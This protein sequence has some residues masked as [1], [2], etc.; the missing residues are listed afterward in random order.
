MITDL[1]TR[2][3]EKQYAFYLKNIVHG[4]PFQPIVLRG[5]KNKPATTAE[6]HEGIRHFRGNEKHI[7]GKGWVIAWE[8]WTSKILGKQQWPSVVSVTTEEDF[9]YLVKKEKEAGRFKEQLGQ[10]LQWN[11]AI[12]NWLA[13]RTRLVLELSAAWLGIC[14]VVDYLLCHDVSG[15]YLRSIPV[16]VHTKFIEQHKKVIHSLIQ[17][18]DNNRLP[19]AALDFE[20][21]LQLHKKPFLFTVRWLDESL[22]ARLSSG[23][24]LFAVPVGYLQ[25]QP[26]KIERVI[27]VENETNLYL[28]PSLPGTLAICSYGKALHL[29]KS[30]DFLHRT[31]L[32]Y[33]GDMDEQ[34]FVMLN[35]LRHYYNHVIS[36]FMDDAAL[37]HHQAELDTKP[38]SYKTKELPM[39]QPHERKAYELLLLHNQWL[40]QEKLHQ[41]YVQE[42]L[43]ALHA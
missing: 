7:N 36:L 14:A 40:E 5:G 6:L 27:L 24:N 20:E 10:L 17:H 22:A 28:L 18:L 43:R 1:Y 9:L 42:K 26:W 2:Q 35:D 8:E 41:L 33:W 38:L 29:L 23:M 12:R 21:A 19:A 3:L 25:Q 11:P 4:E 16:P 31:Q 37:A 34:G 32:Y 39:L 30:V 15:C 13:H